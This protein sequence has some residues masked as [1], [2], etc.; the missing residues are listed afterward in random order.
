MLG[1]ALHGRKPTFIDIFSGCGGLSLGLMQSGWQGLF[2]IEKTHDAFL[3]LKHNLLDGDRY[4]FDWPDWLPKENMEVQ[5]LLSTYRQQLMGLEGKVDLIAGGPRVRGSLMLVDVTLMI[6]ETSWLSS[7]LKSL[8]LLN[9]SFCCLKTFVALTLSLKSQVIL[10]IY[11]I[12][13]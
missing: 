2:A 5:C 4:Q 13:R 12:L 10:T 6:P 9:L 7:T 11:P 8:V 3:T 1:K